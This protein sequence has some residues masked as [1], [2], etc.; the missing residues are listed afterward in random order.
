MPRPPRLKS[1]LDAT[2]PV[3]AP[4]P[5]AP[6]AASA[7]STPPRS[8]PTHIDT[9]PISGALV[10][11][12]KTNRGRVGPYLTERQAD[13]LRACYVQ[14]WLQDHRGTFSD[15]LEQFLLEG[16]EKIEREKNAGQPWPPITA[17]AIKSLSQMNIEAGRRANEPD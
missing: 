15:M 10:G 17:G 11:K 13:R 16:A 8:T 9:P 1:E 7:S 6:V 4:A 2:S 12:R 3:T 5:A 14:G